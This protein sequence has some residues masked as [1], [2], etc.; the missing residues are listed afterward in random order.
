MPILDTHKMTSVV[1][2]YCK[3]CDLY[4]DNLTSM[5]IPPTP[6][7]TRCLWLLKAH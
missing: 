5:K 4:D 3:S 1:S 6:T 2:T 7:P